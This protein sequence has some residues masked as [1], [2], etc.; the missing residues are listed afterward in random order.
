MA[1]YVKIDGIEGESTDSNHSKWILA[2]SASLPVF[3]SIPSGAVDQQRTK[4]ETSL[5]DVTF[6]RQLDKSS[7]KLME[8]CALGKFNKLVTVEFTTTTG[9]KTETYLKWALENAIFTGYSVH[10][11]SSGEPLPSEQVSLNFTKITYTY[12]E[13]DNKT[14]SKKGNVEAKYEMGANKS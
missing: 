3:R 8:A 1:L 11:N 14:G 7:P 6:V 4:G 2:D 10:G 9:G 13:F 5:G 12:T